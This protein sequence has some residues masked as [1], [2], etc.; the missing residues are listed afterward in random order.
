MKYAFLKYL[1]L[2]VVAL[3]VV[4][5]AEAKHERSGTHDQGKRGER[6]KQEL[7]LTDDQIAKL[8]PILESLHQER[9]AIKE[10]TVL[11]KTEKHQQ[12]KALQDKYASQ[13]GA[14]LTPEQQVKWKELRQQHKQA[15]QQ[16]PKKK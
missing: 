1:S 3:A 14:V 6:L 9:K 7:G 2:T 15:H 8:K 16:N 5:M 11:T 13:L 10:D 12:M 4:A